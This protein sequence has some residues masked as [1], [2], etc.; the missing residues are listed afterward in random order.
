MLTK[1]DSTVVSDELSV[2]IT[3]PDA[4][5]IKKSKFIGKGSIKITAS[6]FFYL[7]NFI[8]RIATVK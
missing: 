5:V 8:N 6:V 2:S 4:K 1:A 7:L 3:G